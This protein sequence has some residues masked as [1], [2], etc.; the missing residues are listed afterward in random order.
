M[1]SLIRC[2]DF[3]KDDMRDYR[4]CAWPIVEDQH[5]CLHSTVVEQL[6][7]RRPKRI[8]NAS[9]RPLEGRLLADI[10]AKVPK[11]AAANFPPKNETGDKPF[12]A[13]ICLNQHHWLAKRPTRASKLKRP[14]VLTFRRKS[15]SSSRSADASSRSAANFS[16]R[17]YAD[18]RRA[19]RSKIASRREAMYRPCYLDGRAAAPL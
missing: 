13:R 3:F 16:G 5:R 15:S 12:S 9:E 7:V 19:S 6:T 8:G 14:A 17:R 1:L 18:G 4:G 2:P 10:V 11:G